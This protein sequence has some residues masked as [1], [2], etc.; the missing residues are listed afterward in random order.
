MNEFA[1]KVPNV[2]IPE[3]GQ[4][5]LSWAFPHGI[6]GDM[7]RVSVCYNKLWNLLID[8]NRKKN[9]RLT[10]GMSTTA[11]AR[12]GRNEHVNT[13]IRPKICFIL[14]RLR[15]HRRGHQEPVSQ[16][17]GDDGNALTAG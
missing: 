13:E 6:L 10:I 2:M 5:M 8:K 3:R 7:L 15:F 14:S 17:Q 16:E 9:L 11:L 4:F 1:E 12:P